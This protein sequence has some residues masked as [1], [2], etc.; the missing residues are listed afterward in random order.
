MRLLIFALIIFLLTANCSQ[1][2]SQNNSPIRNFDFFWNE[3]DKHYAQFQIK[4][5]HWDSIYN[6]YRPK[7]DKNTS[8]TLLFQYLSEIVSF[9]DDGHVNLYSPLGNASWN[10]NFDNYYSMKLINPRK[11]IEFGPRQ[12]HS[13]LMEY[14]NLVGEN[15]G[16]LFLKSFKGQAKDYLIIDK[17]I[18]EF[19]DKDGIIIDLRRNGGGRSSNSWLVASR[20][21]DK[22]RL[23]YTYYEKNGKGKN[24]FTDWREKRVAPD[25]NSQFTKPVVILTSQYTFSS[26]EVF[27]MC[28]QS[29]PQVSI[30]GDITAGG[31]GNPINRELPNGWRFRL[32]T[33]VAATRSKNII[34]GKGI[35]P[36][37]LIINTEEDFE[38]GNDRIIEK[39]VEII[40]M[41]S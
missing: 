26:A 16:I 7:I 12:S 10:R 9:I 33:K 31:V 24:D 17:I 30:V 39:A 27:V 23:C 21:A 35:Q 13:R 38:S 22:K 40:N 15:I 25:G 29:F 18:N 20:F 4:G 34:E 5:I 14:R 36:D 8:D 37:C 28:M 3:F 2:Y 19:K 1:R 6:A 41:A 32:S 11:Y